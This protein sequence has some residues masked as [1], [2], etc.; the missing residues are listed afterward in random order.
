MKHEEQEAVSRSTLFN[1]SSAVKQ[2]AATELNDTRIR[3]LPV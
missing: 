3:F 1:P 2:V